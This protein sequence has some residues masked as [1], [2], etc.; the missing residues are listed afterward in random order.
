MEQYKVVY[1]YAGCEWTFG[2]ADSIGEAIEMEARCEDNGWYIHWIM[3]MDDVT[4]RWV[5]AN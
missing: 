1:H 3:K 4:G 2:Y 5:R